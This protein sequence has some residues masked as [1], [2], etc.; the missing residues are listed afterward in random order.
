MPRRSRR[1]SALAAILAAGTACTLAHAQQIVAT[2]PDGVW[3]LLDRMPAEV[4]AAEP[5][6]RAERFAPARLDFDGVRRTLRRAPL[7]GTPAAAA[8]MTLTLPTPDGRFARFAIIE[9][10]VMEAALQAEFPDM[11][12]Y[13]GQGLDDPHATIRLDH[14]PQGFHAQVLSPTG[15]FYIDPFSRGDT[16]HYSVYFKRDLANPHGQWMCHV[17]GE[18]PAPNGG[19]IDTPSGTTL[20]TYRLACAATGEYTAFHGGTVTAG[21]A[22]IVT[23]VNRITG[24]YEVEMALRLVLV[25]NNSSLV[26][27]N[28]GT[29]PYTN[30]NGGTMLGQNQTTC[31]SVIGNANYDIGHVFSTGGGGVAGLGVV[32]V[33]GQKARGVTGLPSPIGDP[34]YID[35]VAHEMGHQF[36]ANHTYNGTNGSCSGGRVASSA[37]EPGSA[38]TIM[39]YA[40]ICGADN[41]QN[42]SDP[43]MHSVS[44]DSII[45][46]TSS[47]AGVGF[48]QT[49]T[50]NSIPV[51]NAGPDYAIPANTPFIL[52]ASATDGNN[53][54]LT[55]CWEERDLGPA[56]ALSAAQN[57][58][59]PIIRAFPP[60]TSPSRMI[61]RLSNLLSNTLATGEKLPL[62][63]RT[64]TFRCTVRDNR[65]NGGGANDDAMVLTVVNTGAPFAVTA[66]NTNVTWSGTQTVTWNVAGTNAAPISTANVSIALSTDGG[67]TFPTVLLA[68]TP[69][70]GSQ[71]VTL[72]AINSTQ[73]RIRVAAVNSVY[74]DIS[75]TNFTIV[76]T[77]PPPNNDCAA[78]TVVRIGSFPFTTVG[79]TTDGP[80][81][82]TCNFCCGDPQVNQDVWFRFAAPCTGEVTASLCGATF[83]TKLAVYFGSCPVG[84]P[85]AC[86]DDSDTCAVGSFQSQLAWDAI[87]GGLYTIRVGGF[88]SAT[89]TGT[90]TLSCPQA[91]YPN[92]D[93]STTAPVLNVADFGCFLTRYAAGEAYANCDGSTT[94]PVLNVA[95]FG[96]FLTR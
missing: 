12:T 42:N 53:D 88:T 74:F 76:G 62:V 4:A 2:S 8:P 75:N 89:G 14:T 73:A 92:C 61:P 91:C 10:P 25:G 82:P 44:H 35:Y 79:A 27:T 60:T 65:A 45:S 7:E 63:S 23:A 52:T 5:W 81:A 69:N 72:P 39:G 71:A 96:C 54:P 31:D 66:P 87:A 18:A 15:A 51:V 37:Y 67:V 70:D 9:S 48:S 83:D 43:F 13:V 55:Y 57:T 80:P 21:Q 50:G 84:T 16:T 28:G 49:A 3:S 59:S 20:R 33:T 19:V 85:L 6:I 41:L 95:D 56:Q 38:S 94:A 78:A 46:Y 90:L 1:A 11:R 32:G 40:G 64:M 34:F 68:S 93:E 24:V 36:A 77:P 22:A 47:G 29:D 86:N 30:N 58:T 26:Y 17:D